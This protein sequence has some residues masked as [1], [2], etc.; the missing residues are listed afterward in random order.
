MPIS[1]NQPPRILFWYIAQALYYKYFQFI[2]D[3]MAQHE[4]STAVYAGIRN[5]CKY[6][7]KYIACIMLLTDMRNVYVYE[8]QQ[9]YLPLSFDLH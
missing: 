4:R 3:R 8:K 6:L 7:R 5:A 2:T 9:I 1:L